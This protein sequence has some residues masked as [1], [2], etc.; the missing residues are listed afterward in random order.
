VGDSKISCCV[1]LIFDVNIATLMFVQS[2]VRLAWQAISAREKADGAMPPCLQ[3][4]FAWL[5][6][7]GGTM[8]KV[9]L[10]IV[11]VMAEVVFALGA[12]AAPPPATFQQLA[13][14][15]PSVR[16]ANDWFGFSI[17]AS[18]NTVV[19]G[20][21]DANIE[22]FG[23]V[24]VYVKP[25]NGWAN[26]TQIATLTSS[27][28]GQG[29]GTSVAISGNTVVVGAAD[30][31]NFNHPAA[32]GPGSAYV[33]VMPAGGWH[34]MTETAKLTASD[35]KNGDAFGDSV[36]I[37][38]NTIAVGAFFATDSSGNSF[39]GK[40]YV[41]VRPGSGWAGDLNETA[42]LTAND[43]ELLNYMGASV[44]I[45]GGTVV[46]G[47]YGHNNFQGVAY[48]FVKPSNGWKNMTQTAEL[49]S[50]DGA[51]SDD[52]G[53]SA[54][55]IGDTIVIGAPNARNSKGSAYVFVE[56][57]SGWTNMTQTSE[58]I[59]GNGV[60]FQSFGQSVATNGKVVVVGAPSTTVGSNFGQG[61]AYVFAKPAS[62]WRNRQS[63]L[64]LIASD[65][66]ANDGFGLSVAISGTTV[67][68]GAP[69]NTTPGAAYVFGQ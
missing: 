45:S 5:E 50:S 57:S 55:I 33:F 58:L 35:G 8:S 4:R 11:V 43:S 24:Y 7:K 29:F 63:N 23:T 54:A 3:T 27:D 26:M 2:A 39:A 21:F 12:H 42:K 69:K 15:T 68:A 56:P 22:Q 49:S 1:S 46:V 62:G 9:R 32:A 25:A 44:G 61:A 38:G 18:G 17:A 65:G 52:F 37:S 67:F 36:A 10:V 66:A 16:G 41:F 20:A 59:A 64:E 31:S 51:G 6:L 14:L 60:Q 47:A 53:F 48:V 40:S 28:S 19:V 13:E 34:D 30:T